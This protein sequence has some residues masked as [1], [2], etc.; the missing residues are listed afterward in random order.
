MLKSERTITSNKGIG[1]VVRMNKD[2]KPK[3]ILD[4]TAEGNRG[5]C[6][7]EW[8]DYKEKIVG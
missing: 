6:R 4:A 8:E 5:I 3:H 2:R 1:H 7:L